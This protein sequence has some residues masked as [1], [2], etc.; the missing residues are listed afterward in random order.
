[1]ADIEIIDTM[2]AAPRAKT[3]IF[4][5]KPP[6]ASQKTLLQLARPFEPSQKGRFT[7]D[8]SK[9]TYTDG[10]HLFTLYRASGAFRYQDQTR[11]QRDDGTA[12]TQIQDAEAVKLAQSVVGQYALAPLNE[13][14][15][16][17]VTRLNVGSFGAEGGKPDQRVIDIGVAFQ[18][19]IA[20]VPVDGPGGKVIVYL[21]HEG[22]PTGFDRT[23]R[24]TAAVYKPVESLLSPQNAQAQLE[25]Y[26]RAQP[27]LIQVTGTR[28][29]Y[30]ERG[31]QE[32][33]RYMQ[34]AYVFLL[35]LMS[36]E[37]RMT[38]NTAFVVAAATNA[39]GTIMPP[40]KKVVSQPVRE[41]N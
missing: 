6:A 29:G 25:R 12:N 31:P 22:K 38:M 26:W 30:F 14:Q 37:Q 24:E 36:P 8:P 28:F 41:G 13:L 7:Q 40:A 19:T 15:L 10:P 18:R 2:K 1:M 33:Q 23:W 27:G 5:L 39:V 20:G 32:T 16:L 21:D 9:L 35:T 4:T 34:P 11:W 3:Q 17:K